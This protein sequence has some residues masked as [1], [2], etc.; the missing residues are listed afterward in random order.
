MP[1]AGDQEQQVAVLE[2]QLRLEGNEMLGIPS[3]PIFKFP[4]KA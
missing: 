2:W 4:P 1:N 3:M